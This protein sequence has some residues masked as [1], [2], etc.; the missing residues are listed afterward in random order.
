[1]GRT[2]ADSDSKD[3]VTPDGVLGEASISIIGPGRKHITYE[4]KIT[5]KVGQWSLTDGCSHPHL[6]LMHATSLE[7]YT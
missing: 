2:R 6:E 3:G 1:M 7:P 5:R 4:V